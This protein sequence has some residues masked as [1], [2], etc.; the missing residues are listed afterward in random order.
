M[1]NNLRL[2]TSTG[3]GALVIEQASFSSIHRAKKNPGYAGNFLPATMS[4]PVRT[5]SP[6]MKV[7]RNETALNPSFDLS[8]RQVTARLSEIE[9]ALYCYDVAILRFSTHSLKKLF[10][11]MSMPAVGRLAGQMEELAGENQWEDVKD[12]LREIKKIIGQIVKHRA[13]PGN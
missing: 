5:V 12:L 11:G 7:Y 6:L 10:L 9:L 4:A 2:L 3:S 1:K 13:Q 8:M